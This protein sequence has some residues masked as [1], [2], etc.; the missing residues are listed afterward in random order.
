M[1]WGRVDS[2]SGCY[3]VWALDNMKALWLPSVFQATHIPVLGWRDW[4]VQDLWGSRKSKDFGAKQMGPESQKVTWGQ[5]LSFLSCFLNR[6][7]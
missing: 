3:L 1:G 7:W 5:H 2:H 4:P 6:V